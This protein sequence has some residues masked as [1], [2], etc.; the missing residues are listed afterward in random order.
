M[1]KIFTT[2]SIKVAISCLAAIAMISPPSASQVAT[3][4]SVGNVMHPSPFKGT[5]TIFYTGHFRKIN[6][7]WASIE[8]YKGPYHPM[9][10]YYRYK[11]KDDLLKHLKWIRRAGVDAIVYDCYGMSELG[12]MDMN[13]DK[14][15]KWIMKALDN[16]EKEARKLKL[17]I[18]IEKYTG[19]PSLKE[20]QSALKFVRENFANK[21]YYFQWQNKPMVLT[22]MN[23][24]KNPDLD[25]LEKE[26]SDFTLRRI[27]AY[28]GKGNWSY[29]NGWPQ[30]VNHEW[31]SV[32]PGIDPFLENAYLGK[33]QGKPL[34]GSKWNRFDRKGGEYFEKQFLAARMVDPDF[35]FISG[36]NDWQYG[37]QIEPAMEYRFKYVD[38][39]AQMLGREE[40]T[41]PYRDE[42]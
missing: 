29:I 2:W 9:L 27:R 16:Q 32:S 28:D 22:Y 10:G 25:Q 8:E 38:Q 40:E 4:D 5:V 12:P 33:R 7:D 14:V 15:L 23:G 19:N 31:M 21:P 30:P 1:K 11:K 36:W 20:Y 18:Y 39:A 6:R 3:K 37:C 26:T 24:D 42:H 41:K 13:K 17:I 35:I 34:D